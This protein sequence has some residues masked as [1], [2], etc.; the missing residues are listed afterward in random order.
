MTTLASPDS[1]ARRL[2]ELHSDVERT[3][4]KIDILRAQEKELRAGHTTS[5]IFAQAAIERLV[6]DR[7]MY[8]NAL[9]NLLKEIRELETE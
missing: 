5:D 7:T 8:E 2:E 4:A 3:R 9:A 1:R 6:S